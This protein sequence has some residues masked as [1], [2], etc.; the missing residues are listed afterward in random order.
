ML[1]VTLRKGRYQS[2][3]KYPICIHYVRVATFRHVFFG[4]IK[5]RKPMD[6]AT[7]TIPMKAKSYS[8]L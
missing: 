3:T 2:I 6:A 4:F 8:L 1:E 5:K 7:I